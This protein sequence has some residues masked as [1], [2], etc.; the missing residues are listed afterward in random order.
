MPK[1]MLKTDQ[2]LSIPSKKDKSF[3]F[4]RVNNLLHSGSLIL[5][6]TKSVIACSFLYQNKTK[7]LQNEPHKLVKN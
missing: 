6:H 1:K 2:F 4:S 5:G 3:F 7:I